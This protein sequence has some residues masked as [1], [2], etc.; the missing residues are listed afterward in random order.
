MD[1]SNLGLDLDL[2]KILDLDPSLEIFWCQ[3]CLLFSSITII[4]C[5]L[6]FLMQT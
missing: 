4:T 1:I 3:K 6:D 5:A 2:V